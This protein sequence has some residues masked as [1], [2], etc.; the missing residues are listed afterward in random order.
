MEIDYPYSLSDTDARS[1]LEILGAY[2]GNRHGI[3]VTWVKP[4]R[5]RFPGS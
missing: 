1:R 4:T 5:A 2:L 3:K